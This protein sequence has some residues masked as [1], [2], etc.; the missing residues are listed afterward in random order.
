[1][2]GRLKALTQHGENPIA[3]CGFF[4]QARNERLLA[5]LS[6]IHIVDVALLGGN[7][8]AQPPKLSVVFAGSLAHDVCGTL[9][10]ASRVP[11][12]SFRMLAPVSM[13]RLA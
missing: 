2:L 11:F 9:V 6:V 7:L 3:Q 1:M 10:R 8:G 5:V 13:P 12:A 4:A